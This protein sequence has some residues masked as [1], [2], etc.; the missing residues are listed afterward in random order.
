MIPIDISVKPG[1]VEHVHIGHKCSTMKI[2]EYQALFKEFLD[3][4]S[5][6]YEKMPRI[7]PSIV[8][9]EIKTYPAEKIVR[10]QIVQ[11]HPRK[12]QPLK[13]KLKNF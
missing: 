1:V 12:V 2:K 10:K 9:L 8:V 7:D 11:V 13:L 5:W 4:F 3:F 6:T